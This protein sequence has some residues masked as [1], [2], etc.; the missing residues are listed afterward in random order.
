L[1]AVSEIEGFA[2]VK[3][4]A[5]GKTAFHDLR[6]KCRLQGGK[7]AA[8][9]VEIF[10][11]RFTASGTGELA[12]EG[13]LNY[14]LNVFLPARIADPA[15]ETAEELGPF[16]L[17]LSGPFAHPELKADPALLPGLRERIGRRKPQE[18]LRN[19]LPEDFLFKRPTSS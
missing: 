1:K 4:K 15:D 7:L 12:P 6:L 3:E 17:L 9:T 13:I 19:F 16:P 14:R 2:A 8:D 18:T 10:S 11:E 5:E